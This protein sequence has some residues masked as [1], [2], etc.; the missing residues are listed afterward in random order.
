MLQITQRS[1][2][3]IGYTSA[4]SWTLTDWLLRLLKSYIRQNSSV[5]IFSLYKTVSS[6]LQLHFY[7]LHTRHPTTIPHSWEWQLPATRLLINT[8]DTGLSSTTAAI[9]PQRA[10]ALLQHILFLDWQHPF[11]SEIGCE[12]YV[13]L[14]VTPQ[15]LSLC[16]SFLSGINSEWGTGGAEGE[17]PCSDLPLLPKPALSY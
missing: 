13:P 10:L 9:Y 16:S 17:V 11:V 15:L 7:A 4:Q 14:Y 8:G 5:S 12:A 3:K 1:F 6:V 2:K